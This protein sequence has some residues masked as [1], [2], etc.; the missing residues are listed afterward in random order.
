MK[1]DNKKW[2]I[3]NGSRITGIKYLISVLLKNRGI[4]TGGD[5]K[6]FLNPT[7][8]MK[9]DIGDLGI[10]SEQVKKA[11]DRIKMAKKN[12]EHVI[13]YGDYDADGITG[14]ATLWETLN[15]LGVFVFPHIP[16]RFSEGYGLN[17]ASVKKLK[18]EDPKITLIITVD[19]G[20]TAGEKISDVKK[21]GIDMII[22]D[23]HQRGEKSPRPVEIG[24]AHV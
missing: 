2:E 10:S 4:K 17:L 1:K 9:I 19:H 8:P 23:H 11:V 22:T 13:I 18:E 7:D 16:E 3:L 15:G 20:I 5:K 12:G 6:E 14:T 21:L 24:R